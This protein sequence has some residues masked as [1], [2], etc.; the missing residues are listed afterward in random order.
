MGDRARDDDVTWAPGSAAPTTWLVSPHLLVAQA[1]AA[2]LRSAGVPAATGTWD[3]PLPP[4]LPPEKSDGPRYVV[5][6]LDGLA[7][8]EVME[9]ILGLTREGG[10]RVV[11]V[12]AGAPA[13]WWGGLLV[14]DDIEIVSMTTSLSQLA[15][16]VARFT[17]GESVMDPAERR[18]LRRG[19]YEALALRR[20]QME[21]LATLSPQQ[22][23]V[24]ELLA[25]GRRV[26]EVAE[27]IGL[28]P[29][30]VR[31][32]VKALR[33]KLGVKTQLEAVAMLNQVYDLGRRADL[34]PRPRQAPADDPEPVRRR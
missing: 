26:A 34:V 19:W 20:E 12:A 18:D 13:V 4:R 6:L 10:V 22:R 16:L 33:A 3:A 23:R 9:Q 15:D 27:I 24:L 17:R 2:A 8:A 25:S 7:T 28:T 5:V 29:A 30:T 11:V 21:R 1:V 14:S 31:S 32:H